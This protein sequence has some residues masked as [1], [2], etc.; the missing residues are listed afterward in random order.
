MLQ[1]LT[2]WKNQ[3]KSKNKTVTSPVKGSNNNKGKMGNKDMSN[4]QENKILLLS[5]SPG[6]GKTTLAHIIAK[7]AG[8]NVI[9][10]NASDDRT[11]DVFEFK[12]LNAIEMES[13]WM[14]DNKPN[15]L[16][17]DEIDGTYQQEG[18]NAIQLL[19]NIVTGNY[20]RKTSKKT[21]GNNLVLQRPIIC[22]CNN[23]Y[24]PV[25]KKLRDVATLFQLEKPRTQK[26]NERLKEISNKEGLKID[27]Q[28]IS[29]ISEMTDCDI[30]SS[31][32]TLQFLRNNNNNNK[33]NYITVDTLQNSLI[34]WKDTTNSN[35]NLFDS[36]KTIFHVSTSSQKKRN[37]INKH[38]N[39]NKEEEQITKDLLGIRNNNS[40][41]NNNYNSTFDYIWEM[42]ES[43]EM[44]DKL[45][46]GSY[47]NM[48][49][50]GYT[51]PT[52][53]KTIEIYNWMCY[54]D[55]MNKSIKETQVYS[56][57]KYKNII[58]LAYHKLCGNNAILPNFQFPK[59]EKQFIAQ[60]N[61]NSEIIK[62][63]LLGVQPSIYC[64][65]TTTIISVDY[66]SYLIDILSPTSIKSV[67]IQLLNSSDKLILLNLVGIMNSL[68]LNYIHNNSTDNN[69]D[70]NNNNNDRNSTDNL[71]LYP[72]IDL[73]LNYSTIEY[74][75]RHK[76]ITPLL[77]QI[78]AQELHKESTRK[79][80]INRNNNNNNNNNKEKEK[81]KIVINTPNK[82]I[83]T[84]VNRKNK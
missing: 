20:K 84:E 9:E 26:L 62:N 71:H 21:T 1:W 51:D 34:G 61:T 37:K 79:L 3:I 72:K 46:K 81:E 11:L 33:N 19:I 24:A 63:F 31:L 41:N 18:N 15:C 4:L 52:M 25:L 32:N 59:S 12:I 54:Y 16:I 44:E 65:L 8:F 39:K 77:Q 82:T 22:I 55:T 49:N 17:I 78:V 10:M 66:L 75:K 47:E 60:L 28:A 29:F 43:E 5:G 83:N 74:S 45:I 14:G 64:H 50:V 70:N 69:K 73:L 40:N 38:T 27:I 58:P 53:S 13:N 2:A 57:N 35:L 67:N 76:Q 56:L 7:H 36:L 48:H 42:V 6:I 68:G 80:D 23:L 30:R